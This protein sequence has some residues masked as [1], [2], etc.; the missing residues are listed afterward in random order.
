MERIMDL[1]VKI[2]E[3]EDLLAYIPSNGLYLSENTYL[4][5]IGQVKQLKIELAELEAN[6]RT[7]LRKL[8]TSN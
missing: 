3:I 4:Y 8:I 6:E 5:L 7:Q 2:R 1:R